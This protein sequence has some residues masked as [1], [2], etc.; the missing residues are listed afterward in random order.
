M[1]VYSVT[2][3]TKYIKNRIEQDGL[4]KNIYLR[5]EI[6]NF[7]QHSSGH[8]YFTLKDAGAVIRAVMFRGKAQYLRFRPTNGMK[9]TAGGSISVF[10]RDGQYQF[11][12]D[13]LL[14]EG[15][16]ELTLAYEECK[17]KL[18]AEGLFEQERKKALP[19]LA[20]KIGIVTSST[21]AVLRDILKVG[22]RRNPHTQFVLYPVQV[23]GNEASAQIANAIRA[24]NRSYAVDVLIVGRGGGAMED[25]WAFNEEATVRAVAASRIPVI[26]AVGHETD[27]TLTDLAADVRAATPSHAAELAVLDYDE[28]QTHLTAQVARLQ[29]GVKRFLREKE[30]QYSAYSP[31]RLARRLALAIERKRQTVDF[32]RDALVMQSSKQFQAKRHRLELGEKRLSIL[33]PENAL[34]RGYSILTNQDGMIVRSAESLTIGERI[35]AKLEDGNV[36]LEVVKKELRDEKV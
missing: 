29:Q 28:W 1:N 3:I 19:L 27:F 36:V 4:L 7:K 2:E 31:E 11:Y 33:C 34:K 35:G 14:P 6:S 13:R 24:F 22:K 25:L 32:V 10:E 9:V 23:Q 21:G 16:G 17:A 15:I 20:R 18:T 26:S 30:A 8:C 12:A 5:G